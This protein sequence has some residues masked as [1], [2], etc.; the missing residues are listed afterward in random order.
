MIREELIRVISF[1]GPTLE[2][3]H[4]WVTLVYWLTI[5]ILPTQV[6]QGGFEIDRPRFL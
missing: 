5:L 6:A 1:P 4:A 3:Y 2:D